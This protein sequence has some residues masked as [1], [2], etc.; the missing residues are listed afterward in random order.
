MT[1]TAALLFAAAPAFAQVAAEPSPPQ[2]PAVTVATVTPTRFV[3]RVPVAGNV[4]ARQEVLVAPEVSGQRVEALEVQVGD[5]VEA[6]DVLARLDQ[7][8]LK[9]QVELQQS[10]VHRTQANLEQARAQVAAQTAALDQADAALDRAQQLRKSGTGTQ[11]TLD[12]AVSNQASAAA[13]LKAAQDTVTTSEAQL[14]EA[15]INRD[16]AQ[17][18]LEN[19]VVTAPVAGIIT[20]RNAMIGSVAAAS[21]EPMFRILQ[22]GLVDVETEVIETQLGQI[23]LGDRAELD[24]AGVGPLL[25]HVRRIDPTVDA[26]SRLGTVQIEPEN[27]LGLRP[28]LFTGGW[29][30]TAERQSLG[31]PV[32][33]VIDET[34][35]A[36]VF[37]VEDGVLHRRD[38]TPGLF[39][40][41]NREILSGLKDGDTVLARAAGFFSDGDPV[42]P[43]ATT[44]E[45]APIA[46][47]EASTET[48]SE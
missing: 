18:D 5:S 15:E 42:R 10:V 14:R 31:V 21:G 32:S 33:A 19:S 28:G 4:V 2:P 24:V 43:L 40:N 29:I 8:V 1:L 27:N 39:W 35:G 38:V 22:G 47:P 34:G 30:I 26:T 13:A 16:L 6:G 7:R 23:T 45:A 44:T 9:R 3:Q 48:A 12:Q 46:P 36:W 25:G 41:G 17:E 20:Q 11:A 37:A